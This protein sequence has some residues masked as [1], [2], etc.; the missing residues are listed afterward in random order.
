MSLRWKSFKT[1][2]MTENCSSLQRVRPRKSAMRFLL[3]LWSI[4]A[5]AMVF[6]GWLPWQQTVPGGGR[7]VAYSPD[8]RRQEISAP[9]DARIRRWHV[10]E[11]QKVKE[12]DLLVELEDNDPEILKRLMQEREAIARRVHAANTALETARL[13]ID[14]QQTLLEQGLSAPISLEQARLEYARHL[15]EEANA[16]A[17]L[18]R[19]DVRLSRQMNQK[20][21]APING[22]IQKLMVGQGGQIVK[23]GQHLATLVPETESRGVELWVEGR[24]MPLIQEGREVRLQFE[25]WPA[26]Q[27]SGWPS[28][29]IGT[30]GGEVGFVDE[31]DDGQGKFRI[32]IFPSPNELWPEP[33]FLRQGVR[34]KGWVQLDVVPLGFEIWRLFNGFP[35]TVSPPTGDGN[36]PIKVSRGVEKR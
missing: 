16:A 25:G 9:L 7:V 15:A 18:S 6:C 21:T 2:K 3:I 33:R 22:S 26:I 10:A 14:R 27:F 30:F 4:C 11:G 36:E 8:E 12:G 32:L 35:P 31:A 24:D 29:A 20:V 23:Q 19:M 1:I 34:V 17:E 28:V 5:L 13:N